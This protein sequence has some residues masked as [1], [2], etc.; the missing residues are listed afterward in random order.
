M[1]RS[2]RKI[3]CGHCGKS[4]VKVAVDGK[5]SFH[6]I[7]GGNHFCVKS[8]AS[9]FHT[10]AARVVR[11]RRREPTLRSQRVHWTMREM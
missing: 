7:G 3:A 2:I 4:V 10:D 6:E 11:R 1:A 9:V 8:P 5:E